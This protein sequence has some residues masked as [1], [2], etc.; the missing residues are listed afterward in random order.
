M[1]DIIECGLKGAWHYL[2]VNKDALIA[3]VENKDLLSVQTERME[4]ECLL[5][6]L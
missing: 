1:T 4:L 6:K 3:V 2:C 5:Q